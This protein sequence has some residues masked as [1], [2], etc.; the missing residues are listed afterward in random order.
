MRFGPRRLA[1]LMPAAALLLTVGAGCAQ[2]PAPSDASVLQAG[3]RQ[4]DAVHVPADWEIATLPNSG[5][6]NGRLYWERA[7]RAHLTVEDATRVYVKAMTDAGWTRDTSCLG[8]GDRQ[9]YTYD[10]DGLH[11]FPLFT[12]IPCLDG[13]HPCTRVAID[14]SV[15][16]LRKIKTAGP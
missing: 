8:P 9:C 13:S 5:R 1:A 7:Y 16:S 3:E 6:R 14:A 15:T 12:S 4:L 10:K 2:P 11:V